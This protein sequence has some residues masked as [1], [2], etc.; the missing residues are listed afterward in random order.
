[1]GNV[2]EAN[3]SKWWRGNSHLSPEI[4]QSL[5]FW[6]SKKILTWKKYGRAWKTSYIF[7]LHLR[8]FQHIWVPLN[9][10]MTGSYLHVADVVSAW[11]TWPCNDDDISYIIRPLSGQLISPN[12]RDSLLRLSVISSVQHTASNTS[13]LRWFLCWMQEIRN[14]RSRSEYVRQRHISRRKLPVRFNTIAV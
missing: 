4:M 14:Q 11:M 5:G 2:Y 1:M 12:C 8:R 7:S 3:S 9:F 6:A 10:S 13:I